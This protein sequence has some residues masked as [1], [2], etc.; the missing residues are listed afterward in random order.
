MDDPNR[1]IAK[2]QIAR[3]LGS[4]SNP[5]CV[6][7]EED[8]L[9]FANEAM[10][11]L[12]GRS[13][14]SLLG[15]QCSS[16]LPDDG[17]CE[18]L[19]SAF[20]ALPVHWSR[21][22]LKLMPEGISAP[23][24]Q[25]HRTEVGTEVGNELAPSKW[26]RCLIPLE[27]ESG[28]VLC[29]F[30]PNANGVLDAIVDEQAAIV[31]T[32]LRD[33][34]N[35]YR[36]L[37]NMWFLQGKS[38]HARRVLEQVQLAIV[39]PLPLTVFGQKGSGRSWLAQSIQA[40]RRGNL[41]SNSKFVNTKFAIA[42]SMIRIDCSLMDIELLQSMLE[43]VDESTIHDRAAPTVSLDNLEALPEECVS[44]LAS[45][46]KRHEETVCIATCDSDLIQALSKGKLQW[47]E[48]L[49]RTSIIRID[50]PRLVDRI[51]DLPTL[52]SAWF[53]AQRK[54][55]HATPEIDDNFLDA[56]TAYSWPGDIEELAVALTHV[57]KNTSGE[58]LT[59]RDLPVNIRTCVSHIEQSHADESVDLDSILEDVEKTMIL[60]ALERYPQNKTSAAKI[61]NISRARLL[62]RLQHWGIK[63][64]GVSVEG[65]DDSPVFNEV[66]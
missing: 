52:I 65:D 6:L 39:N 45:F 32:I 17:S 12:V 23:T 56:L 54:T 34:R 18:A 16:P 27:E 31:Q 30:C 10:G 49:T 59:D 37:D 22:F 43:V 7:S 66:K 57:A 21:K 36:Y 8:R 33:N 42:D 2:R 5:I 13:V 4:S 47:S 46:L 50:L 1:Y 53:I 51:E 9:V 35:K 24:I 29:I 62:R 60:R 20:F 15:L 64:E 3:L 14:E 58:T 63:S 55:G 25:H 40:Q 44:L 26:M 28:C 38:S 19:L 48:V 11:K 61:L 41:T